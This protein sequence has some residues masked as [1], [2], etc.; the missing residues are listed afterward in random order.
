VA[1]APSGPAFAPEVYRNLFYGIREPVLVIGTDLTIWDANEAAVE[2]LNYGSRSRLLDTPVRSILVNNDVLAEV[3]DHVATDREWEGKAK[4][5]THDG[6]VLV[7]SGTAV[8]I[9][10]PDG[11]PVIVG[12]FTDLTRRQQYTRSLKVLNRVL[13]HNLRND[14]NVVI[15]HL[16]L[17][18]SEL[19]ESPAAMTEV[20]DRLHGITEQARKARMLESLVR[21]DD[22]HEL[23]AVDVTEYVT[24]VVAEARQRYGDADIAGPDRADPAMV[25]G[26]ETIREAIREVVGNA[27]EHNDVARPTV[28][29]S[30]TVADGNVVVAVADDGPGIDPDRQERVFGREERGPLHH[31]SGVGMFFVDQVVRICG[32]TAWIEGNDPRGT[33]VKLRFPRAD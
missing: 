23:S 30:V 1:D 31:G 2:L 17:L 14:I 32:G 9:E 22:T 24:D 12:V 6:R 28:R 13:R 25:L 11:E 5:R 26:Y 18:Q 10:R 27:V 19:D 15:G 33:V 29:T 4:I 16:E 7:G 21:N 20:F 8:P 3:A